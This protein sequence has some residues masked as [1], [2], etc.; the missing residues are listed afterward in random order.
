MKAFIR[1]HHESILLVIALLLLILA[2]FNPSTKITRNIKSY[3]I[4]I[5]VTQS[6]NV[7]DM[8][9]N[10]KTVSRLDFAKHLVKKT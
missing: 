6:M 7:K 5:G 2:V 1:L 4:L 9:V 10:G 8:K 3:M